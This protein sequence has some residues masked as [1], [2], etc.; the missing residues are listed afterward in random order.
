MV[1]T[2][3]D[4]AQLYADAAGQQYAAAV[5][6]S[7][8]GLPQLAVALRARAAALDALAA[9]HRQLSLAN[10]LVG[11]CHRERSGAAEAEAVAK[12]SAA[13]RAA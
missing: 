3:A 5:R 1:T 2:H 9:G 12:A 11:E 4:A 6:A 8:L 7:Q 13:T 10:R